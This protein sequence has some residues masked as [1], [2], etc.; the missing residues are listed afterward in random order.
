MT[1]PARAVPQPSIAVSTNPAIARCHLGWDPVYNHYIAKGWHRLSASRHAAYFYRA[2]MPPFTS[3][4]NILDFI[5]C[6][7]HGILIGAIDPKEASRLIYA[8]TAALTALRAMPASPNPETSCP[9][10][11][12][13]EIHPKIR[14]NTHRINQLQ[15]QKAAN[16]DSQVIENTKVKSTETPEKCTAT[17]PLAASNR[18]SSLSK[19]D[20]NPSHPT[21][22]LTKPAQFDSNPPAPPSESHPVVQT[23]INSE[24]LGSSTRLS[25]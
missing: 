1:K 14:T 22:P 19:D 17:P 20:P 13:P 24:A 4:Q 23:T 2:A 7:A 16:S 8:A 9:P 6:A 5:A 18:V 12:H 15:S 11:H 10:P 3:P 25:G 21:P